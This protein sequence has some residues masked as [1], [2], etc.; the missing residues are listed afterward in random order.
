VR[1]VVQFASLIIS[2]IVMGVIALR[3]QRREGNWRV[4]L[5]VILNMLLTAAYYLMVFSNPTLG[6]LGDFSA[7]LRLET[8]LTFLF[9]VL[10]M[11]RSLRRRA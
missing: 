4:W 11:P 2:I 7:A 1:D 3:L 10:Y 8:T 5:P 9:Y 6:V